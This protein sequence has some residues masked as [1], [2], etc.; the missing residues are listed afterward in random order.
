MMPSSL[1]IQP[2]QSHADRPIATSILPFRIETDEYSKRRYIHY[3]NDTPSGQH[4]PFM[5]EL[6]DPESISDRQFNSLGCNIYKLMRLYWDL[7]KEKNS[8]LAERDDLL[9]RLA[10][11]EADLKES[12]AKNVE[13]ERKAKGQPNVG[14]RPK[15]EN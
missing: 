2:L 5:V 6:G 14:G 15:K 1:K 12:A 7:E 10:I 3:V 13:W 4:Q 11:A 9:T 8:W